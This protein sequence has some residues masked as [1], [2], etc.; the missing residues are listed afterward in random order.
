SNN[1]ATEDTV[2]GSFPTGHGAFNQ[3]TIEKHQT[4]P[5]KANTARNAVVTYLVTVGNTGTDPAVG[6]KVRDSLPIGGR[7][8]SA[9]GTNKFLCTGGNEGGNDVV[10]CLGGE[11]SSGGSAPITI[12]MFAPDVPG[13]YTN[14]A[15]VDPDNTIPEGDELDNQASDTTTVTNGGEGAVNDLTIV[16]GATAQTVPG[17]DITYTL[18]VS[19]PGSNPA[20]NGTVID[21][22]PAGAGFVSASDTTGAPGAFTCAFSAGVVECTGATIDGTPTDT[23]PGVPDTRTITILVK[24]PNEIIPSYLNKAIVDPDNTIP[25]GNETNNTS[26]ATTNI[27]P[28]INLS[29]TKNGPT[30]SSQSQTTTYNIVVK[31]NAPGGNPADGQLATGVKMHDPL[32]VGLIPLAIDTGSGN[33]WACQVLQNPINV[34]DCVGDLNPEQEVTIKIDVF[35]TAEGGRSLDNEACVDPNDVFK[36]F[37]PGE[38]DNCSTHTTVTN[39]TK[40]PDILVTKNVDATVSTPGSTLT[41]AVV[42]ANVGTA[43]AKGALKVTDKVPDHTTFVDAIGGNGWS[44][45]F[46]SGTKVITCTNPASPNDTFAV[47]ASAQM[48][49]HVTIDNDATLPIA[50]TAKSETPATADQSAADCTSPN[51]CQDETNTLNDQS[52][53]STSLAGSGVGI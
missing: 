8:I 16:K 52:T 40:F 31:N 13:T 28:R 42:V 20:R 21:V 19:N 30:T 50:N 22:L 29:L 53:V 15:I 17:G 41:Y 43:P 9:V 46:D 7:F 11:I 1:I 3:L 27:Q 49:I 23:I 4:S 26:T 5:N 25:E 32:P 51:V 34:V 44:C 37:P 24:A 14:I 39:P 33:N 6:I 2:V 18:T 45:S 10:T 12:L 38:T 35:M 48:T 36:E 47:G